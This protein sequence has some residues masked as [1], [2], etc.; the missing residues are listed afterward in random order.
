M[1]SRNKPLSFSILH[2]QT[3]V[4]GPQDFAVTRAD[5]PCYKTLTPV[6]GSYVKVLPTEDFLSV[7]V[8]VDRSIVE[9]FLQGGRMAITSRVYPRVA[10]DNLA[11]LYLFNNGTTP[12]TVRSVDVYHMTH[13]VMHP[14]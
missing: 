4:N 13:V 8:L 2:I 6:Y 10:V 5:H 3:T 14:I 12:V 9:S 7:C 1:I 11:N